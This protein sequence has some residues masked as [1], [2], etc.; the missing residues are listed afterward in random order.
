MNISYALYTNIPTQQ[1]ILFYNQLGKKNKPKNKEQRLAHRPNRENHR[2]LN[3]WQKKRSVKWT[4]IH[5]E[6]Q[7][8]KEREQKLTS[9]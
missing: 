6:R 3:R 1:I 7:R 8:E 5:R 2:P 4:E 9:V